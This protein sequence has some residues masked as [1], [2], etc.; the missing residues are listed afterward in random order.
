MDKTY[1]GFTSHHDVKKVE[2]I[3]QPTLKA[4]GIDCF[5]RVKIIITCNINHQH[6]IYSEV[7]LFGDANNGI[8]IEFKEEQSSS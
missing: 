2:I 6:E 4:E 5:S 1:T 7:N 3:R 8:E